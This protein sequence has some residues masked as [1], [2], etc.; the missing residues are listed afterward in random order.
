MN[1]RTLER[2]FVEFLRAVDRFYVPI[3]ARPEDTTPDPFQEGITT[4]A[5][6][7]RY[8]ID[9]RALISE[10]RAKEERNGHLRNRWLTQLAEA[11][12]RGTAAPAEP[13]L[14]VVDTEL[15]KRHQKDTQLRA[16]LR[17]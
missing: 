1:K 6:D 4:A 15:L 3:K 5:R 9:R 2:E 8:R 13:R 10:E 7:M 14:E 11:D 12:K 16:E 17:R